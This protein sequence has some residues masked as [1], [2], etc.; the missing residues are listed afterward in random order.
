M[1]NIICFI[2]FAVSVTM[3]SQNGSIVNDQLYL[4]Y[5]NAYVNY[6][7]KVASSISDLDRSIGEFN[8]NFI[9][10]KTFVSFNKSNDKIKWLN[11][12]YKKTGF[13]NATQAVSLYSA[14]VQL[15][16]YRTEM[17]QDLL[18]LY[19]ELL[20]KYDNLQIYNALK[21]RLMNNKKEE[22]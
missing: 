3:Y 11:K 22:L 17:G 18:M 21:Q 9:N 10:E 12:N 15:E 16:E 4:Q 5:E 14:I 2:L 19:N 20:A 6:H 7:V 8:A 13:Q 1:K